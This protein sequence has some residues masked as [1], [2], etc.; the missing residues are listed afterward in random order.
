[1][2]YIQSSRMQLGQGVTV[3]FQKSSPDLML[4][5]GVLHTR[6]ILLLQSAETVQATDNHTSGKQA[7]RRLLIAY[8]GSLKG[9]VHPSMALP[10]AAP[11]QLKCSP[12][13]CALK[14]LHLSAPLID[15][16]ASIQQQSTLDNNQPCCEL[17]VMSCFKSSQQEI[18]GKK[19]PTT[20]C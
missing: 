3:E 14:M 19:K 7:P 9:Q 10:F 4:E 17:L 8:T 13:Q 20:A 5:A 15:S 11:Q 12:A 2:S 18:H 16:S 6:L 1:M